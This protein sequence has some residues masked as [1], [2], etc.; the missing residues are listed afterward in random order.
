MENLLVHT[1]LMLEVFV[2][3]I[4]CDLEDAQLAALVN[5]HVHLKILLNTSPAHPLTICL[6]HG[7]QIGCE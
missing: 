1:G 3:L 5:G 4:P 2:D 7:D 6:V